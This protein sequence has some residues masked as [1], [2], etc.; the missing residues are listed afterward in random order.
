MGQQGTR[1]VDTQDRSATT[2]SANGSAVGRA[3]PPRA[4]E[5]QAAAEGMRDEPTHEEIAARAHEI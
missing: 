1:Q 4:G 2:R 3:T 5:V